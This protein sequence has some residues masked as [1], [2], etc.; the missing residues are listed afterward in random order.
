MD[1]F[2]DVG[3]KLWPTKDTA[4]LVGI[5][6]IRSNSVDLPCPHFL[7]M[8][9]SVY[10]FPTDASK[11]DQCRAMLHDL[12]VQPYDKV[13]IISNNRWE[14]A[15]ISAAAYSLNAAIVPMYEAQLAADW[16]YILNDSG[17]KT[18]FVANDAILHTVNRE[19]LENC[20]TVSTVLSMD[21]PI[22][23]PHSLA[24]ALANHPADSSGQYIRA[25]T[26]DDLANLIYTSGTTGKPK[27]VELTHDNFASNI[28]G[29]VR[30]LVKD[31]HDFFRSDDVSLAF[32]PWA[33]SYGQTCELWALLGHGGS[34]GISRGIPTILDDLQ[35]VRPTLLFSVPTL[36]KKVYDGVH[37]LIE[38]SS[39][40][41]KAL[42]KRALAL[43]K[44]S[45]DVKK[46]LRG[47]LGFFE[48]VQYNALNKIVL[49]KIRARFGGRMR[50]VW[51]IFWH[52][53][54]DR[55]MDGAFLGLF[56]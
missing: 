51:S 40:I 55:R 23:K 24:T 41:R 10:F 47:P 4:F 54:S 38:T 12:N 27:G 1:S 52:S 11:V 49:D 29:A 22:G 13:G 46:G 20:P 9:Y 26:P 35:Q 14:W 15:T 8:F 34:M 28:H 37:N 53:W 44:E 6:R 21:A 45:L 42:M 18:L 33:H 56:G 2:F 50:Y 7:L 16:T 36:Y 39:P 43:G 48:R 3:W 17:A 25:P 31:P 30:S 32:L 19:V 5:K